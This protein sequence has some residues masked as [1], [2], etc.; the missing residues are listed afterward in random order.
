VLLA[1]PLQ[2][3][4]P[5]PNLA[6]LAAERETE[7]ERERN[8]YT[9]RQ[10]VAIEELDDHGTPRGHYRE[11]RDIIF[12]P[13]HDRIEQMIGQPVSALKNLV[14]TEEDF[15]DIRNI[16]PLVLTLDRLWN[17][18]TKFKGEEEVDQVDCWVL[19]VRPRQML[20]GMRYFD[21][22]VGGQEGIQHRAHGGTSRPADPH[23]Q[24][25]ESLPAL[26]YG[27]QAS[28]WQALVPR[29]HLFG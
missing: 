4:D 29:L 5:P 12:S 20:S 3:D 13:E 15:A 27:P 9:Y 21:G 28:R 7:T 2:A 11:V 8:E 22:M 18:E 6:R 16:Q 25:G 23:N 17:Y 26:H 24:A 10:T 1:I 14:L 19:Q